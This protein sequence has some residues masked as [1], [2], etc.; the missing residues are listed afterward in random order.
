[1]GSPVNL[2]SSH[3][4]VKNLLYNG[5]FGIFQRGAAYS[6]TANTFAYTADR[7]GFFPGA[8]SNYSVNR[9]SHSNPAFALGEGRNAILIQRNV[10]N[11][12]VTGYQF[13]QTLER[14]ESQLLAGKQ[15]T[16]SFNAYKGANYSAAGNLL[17]CSILYT[18]SNG[19]THYITG[20]VSPVVAAEQ[21]NV[22]TGASQRFSLT[23]T[24][25]QLNIVGVSVVFRFDTVGTAGAADYFVLEDVM[26]EEGPTATEFET[27]GRNLGEELQ[28]CQRYY[29][30]GSVSQR[31]DHFNNGAATIGDTHAFNTPK[32]SVPITAFVNAS[33]G[34]WTGGLTLATN[35]TYGFQWLYTMGAGGV[36]PRTLVFSWTANAEL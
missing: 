21:D 29:E 23:T 28:L 19:D 25:P 33:S 3:K 6:G 34:D 4:K 20:W 16:L 24:L 36:T 7:W 32:R 31:H 17:K 22:L 13:A 5:A 2:I 27:R 15:L 1:M 10:G 14:N 12:A 11:T 30:V 18:L 35:T 9:T 26:L 8:V